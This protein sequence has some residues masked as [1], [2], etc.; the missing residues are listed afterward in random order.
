MANYTEEQL[1]SAREKLSDAI[2]WRLKNPSAWRYVVRTAQKQAN[3]GK[4]VSG[5]QLVEA[6]RKK[7][8]SDVDG[9]PTRTNNDYAAVI[10][11]WLVMERPYL[12]KCIE[13]RRTALDEIMVAY[14]G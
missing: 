12:S 6:V 10:V 4:Q 5:R 2:S 7:D 3:E 11:R 13:F 14:H 8:F 1:A 9:K